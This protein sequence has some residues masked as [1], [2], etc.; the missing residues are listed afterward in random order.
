M[1]RFAARGSTRRYAKR[2]W[3]TPGLRQRGRNLSLLTQLFASLSLGSSPDPP[4]CFG[5]SAP[6]AVRGSAFRARSGL[7]PRPDRAYGAG[8]VVMA[9][10]C[11]FLKKVS[12]ICPGLKPSFFLL[13][14]RGP[15]GPLF[16]QKPNPS[17]PGA[18]LGCLFSFRAEAT[19]YGS[20]RGMRIQVLHS[21]RPFAAETQTLTDA[22]LPLATHL[23]VVA[24]VSRKAV[25]ADTNSAVFSTVGICP[26]LS[27]AT[28]RAP[29]IPAAYFSPEE[30][31]TI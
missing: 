17:T 12:F 1:L 25:T 13:P 8:I 7:K 30:K 15:K 6:R 2:V 24:D 28:R 22:W 21:R 29:G 11:V 3:G 26:H 5:A 23:F 20:P 10:N 9:D 31:G 27:N 4:L 14:L 19:G 16:H 18:S